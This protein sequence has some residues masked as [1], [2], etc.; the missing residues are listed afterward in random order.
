MAAVSA[1]EVPGFGAGLGTNRESYS[2]VGEQ[3][4]VTCD[5]EL[6]ALA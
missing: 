5:A 1:T 4:V 6:N 2:R 3:P